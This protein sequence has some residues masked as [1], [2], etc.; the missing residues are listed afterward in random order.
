MMPIRL[1]V[2]HSRFSSHWQL[3]VLVSDAMN[4]LMNE[5]AYD[6]NC[7]D[8]TFLTDGL[9]TCAAIV[10]YG[11][12]PGCS[13]AFTHMSSESILSD[14]KRKE[15]ALNQMLEYVLKKNN[16]AHVKMIIY[17]PSI[18]EPH[19]IQFIEQWSKDTNIVSKK[20]SKGGDSAIFNIDTTGQALMLTTSLKLKKGDETKNTKNSWD[21]EGVVI[22][23]AEHK[24][25]NDSCV[26][27][28]NKK[29]RATFNTF[30]SYA[31]L[32]EENP[33]PAHLLRK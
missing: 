30:F 21:G 11:E 22:A 16:L 7:G 3:R 17:P 13:M 32:I 1:K 28:K 15:N 6:D 10:I 12:D 31:E 5:I 27:S 25:R 18:E 4:V 26:V 33:D 9:A 20:L 23:A 29:R 2:V 14:D 8:K 24:L 19:L